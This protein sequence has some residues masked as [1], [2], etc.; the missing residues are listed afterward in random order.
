VKTAGNNRSIYRRQGKRVLDITLAGLALAVFSPILVCL[1]LLIYVCMRSPVFFRQSRPG[2][3]GQPFSIIKFRTMKILTDHQGLLLSDELRL[4]RLGRVLRTLSLDELPEL[5]NVFKGEMSLVGPRPLL[6]EYLP[7]YTREQSRRHDVLPGITGW[8]QVN[9]RNGLS[10][11]EKF[12]LDVW[13]VDNVSFWL[14]MKILG[15]TVWKTIRR[16]GIN[17]PG[18]ATAARFEG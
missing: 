3:R 9:G 4:G 7:R 6:L 16:E 15:L 2:L 1:G 11:E 10:W 17:E 13:Y 12:R 8:A 14:D 18:Q 5:W